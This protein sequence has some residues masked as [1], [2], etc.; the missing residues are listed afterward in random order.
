MGLC[1]AASSLDAPARGTPSAL[2]TAPKVVPLMHRMNS[3]ELRPGARAKG[4][5]LPKAEGRI[6]VTLTQ[7][8]HTEYQHLVR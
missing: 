8:V 5:A 1:L 7:T 2:A 3:S 4:A 6:S